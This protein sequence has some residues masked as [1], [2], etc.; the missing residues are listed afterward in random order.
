MTTDPMPEVP[1]P[2]LLVEIIRALN[3]GKT[4]TIFR[5]EC[6]NDRAVV[7]TPTTIHDAKPEIE[8]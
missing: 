1:I 5:D 7:S 6:G 3:S 4:V 8:S 2:F